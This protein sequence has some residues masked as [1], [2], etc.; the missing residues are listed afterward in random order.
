MEEKIL[1]II[2][3]ICEDSVVREERD[4]DLYE[5]DLIDS[6]GFVELL[7][8]IEDECGVLI[9]PSEVTREELSTVNKIIALVESR[10]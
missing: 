2:E 8:R 7:V 3:E 9:H 6:L 10:A 5:E 1:T 4:L